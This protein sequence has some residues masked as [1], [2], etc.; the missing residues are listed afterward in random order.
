MKQLALYFFSLL[1]I[2]SC[3]TVE[4]TVIEDAEGINYDVSSAQ[5]KLESRDIIKE[6]KA[7]IDTPTTLIKEINLNE[8]K[9]T[10]AYNFNSKDLYQVR[11]DDLS[12]IAISEDNNSK[13]EAAYYLKNEDGLL[14][15]VSNNSFSTIS[16]DASIEIN[17]FSKD[18]EGYIDYILSTL[19]SIEDRSLF[20]S[21]EEYLQFFNH[22]AGII[23]E[24]KL[25]TA[26]YPESSE[27]LNEI[28]SLARKYS[29]KTI[30]NYS[31]SIIES[32]EFNIINVSNAHDLFTS[33]VENKGPYL[34]FSKPDSNTSLVVALLE[35]LMGARLSAIEDCYMRYFESKYSLSES[36]YRYN[37]IK[38]AFTNNLK[39][40]T[41]ASE[42]EDKALLHLSVSY[43]KNSLSLTTND[44]SSLRLALR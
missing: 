3:A 24:N 6:D 41:G 33:M 23:G 14:T 38:D 29:I 17:V 28:F 32:G 7:N 27:R 8:V 31:G 34:I 19:S 36:D 35:A 43:L 39:M 20:T 4:P 5:I 1:L 18:N 9:T 26:S 16:M 12:F 10:I 2:I 30:I 13:L 37:I 21:N 15:I 40:I 22:K 44:I 25:F 42:L 11:I